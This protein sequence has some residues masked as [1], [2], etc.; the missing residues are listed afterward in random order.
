MS[1]EKT[2][3][4]QLA[5]NRAKGEVSDSARKLFSTAALPAWESLRIDGLIR[6]LWVS[7]V[8]YFVSF[9]MAWAFFIGELRFS[10]QVTQVVSIAALL[11]YI[12][13]VNAACRIQY[14]LYTTGVEKSGWG[15]ALFW[16]LFLNPFIVGWAVP[17]WV[18][19]RVSAARSRLQK[20]AESPALRSVR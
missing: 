20:G 5:A 6:I 14:R 7:L 18:L 3:Q 12:V 9:G 11:N 13:M 16:S 4:Q 8:L 15:A 10:V 1:N 2:L 19:T 17:V